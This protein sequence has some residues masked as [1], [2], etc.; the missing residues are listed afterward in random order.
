MKKEE[1]PSVNLACML[2]TSDKLLRS[3]FNATLVFG[4]NLSL[5]VF[6]YCAV[7][8][9][10]IILSSRINTE[11]IMF[12]LTSMLLPLGCTYGPFATIFLLAKRFTVVASALNLGLLVA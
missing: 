5:P 11:E 7:C 1:A 12:I 9:S 6:M 2:S 3:N 10:V 4:T 8:F